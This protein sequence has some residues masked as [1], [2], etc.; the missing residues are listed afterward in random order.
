MLPIENSVEISHSIAVYLKETLGVDVSLES[1]D[2]AAQLPPFLLERY[3][4]YRVEL[5]GLQCVMMI[6]R[7][8]ERKTPAAI[9]KHLQQVAARWNS[10]I[11]YA[12]KTLSATDR[13][14]LVATNVP[15]IIPGRQLYLPPLGIDFRERFSSLKAL[16]RDLSPVA[17]LIV[18]G[19]IL[20]KGWAEHSQTNLAKQLGYT[21]MTIGRAFGEIESAG[22]ATIQAVGRTKRLSFAETGMK[23]WRQ[24]LPKMRS[25]VKTIA[26]VSAP[27]VRSDF[28][29]SGFSAL[30]AYT[31]IAPPDHTVFAVRA[32]RMTKIASSRTAAS[33]VSLGESADLVVLELWTYD[34]DCLSETNRVDRLSLYLSLRGSPDERVEKALDEL[35]EGVRW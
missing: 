29:L 12:T 17:Q 24:A 25:P 35:L 26:H 6:D 9:R 33:S 2:H 21:K 20:G 19:V 27:M 16:P 14:R 3:A 15:F 4:F 30:A 10:G 23:L 32:S 7:G 5:L 22:L 28:S 1:W 11:L 13:S 31:N 18:L 34:P 8:T